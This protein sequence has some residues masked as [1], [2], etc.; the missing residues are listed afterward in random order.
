MS[1]ANPDRRKFF[2]AAA[3]GSAVAVA[4]VAVGTQAAPA[5]RKSAPARGKGYRVTE[6]VRNYYRTAK[7]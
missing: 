2:A 7:T 1:A 4:A 6:H 3:A 5:A